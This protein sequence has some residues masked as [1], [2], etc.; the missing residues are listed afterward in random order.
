VLSDTSGAVCI[1]V[2]TS[3][4]PRTGNRGCF[5]ECCRRLATL[6]IGSS[7]WFTTCLFV[8]LWARLA[9]LPHVFCGRPTPLR[10]PT[11]ASVRSSH[12][13][14]MW[15]TIALSMELGSSLPTCPC[16]NDRILLYCH[17]VHS[18]SPP[19]D[20]LVHSVRMRSG[21]QAKRPYSLLYLHCLSY[22]F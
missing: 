1:C 20:R 16:V 17:S 10:S 5:I 4:L 14:P 9:E 22:Q 11:P 13:G 3:L 21:P 15:W 7:L 8:G 2:C 6:A 19:L 12:C 18:I